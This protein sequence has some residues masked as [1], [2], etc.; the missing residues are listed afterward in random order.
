[1][2][3]APSAIGLRISHSSTNSPDFRKRSRN[4]CAMFAATI[5][6]AS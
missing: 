2:T 6:V 5:F 3:A 4:F 1:M